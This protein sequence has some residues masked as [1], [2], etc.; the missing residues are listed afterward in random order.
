MAYELSGK[1]KVYELDMLCD[2]L[3]DAKILQADFD[4][5]DR[6]NKR[7][8]KNHYHGD[9]KYNLIVKNVI[10]KLEMLKVNFVVNVINNEKLIEDNRYT[11][12][13]EKTYDY[14]FL[15][16]DKKLSF[17]FT[18]LSYEDRA[19]CSLE[20]VFLL[21]LHNIKVDAKVLENIFGQTVTRHVFMD[22]RNNI[23]EV[24][25]CKLVKNKNGNYHFER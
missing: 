19:F 5:S 8:Y 1:Q 7:N 3:D 4:F 14:D 10:K 22:I 16:Y 11:T 24:L 25:N 17:S 6:I 15:F 13:V 20:I 18:H 21:L 12:Y 2:A 23:E 9:F